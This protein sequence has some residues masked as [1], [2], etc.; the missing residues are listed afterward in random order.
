MSLDPIQLVDYVP[1][2]PEPLLNAVALE[3]Q[4]PMILEIHNMLTRPVT[5]VTMTTAH[6]LTSRTVLRV[7]YRFMTTKL[8][9]LLGFA[10][11]WLMPEE[12]VQVSDLERTILVGLARQDLCAGVEVL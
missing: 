4:R 8:E 9:V 7:L 10:P 1:G 3:H 2:F 6:R 12:Q 11:V 5:T